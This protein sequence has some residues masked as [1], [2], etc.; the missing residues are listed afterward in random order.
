MPPF[1]APLGPGDSAPGPL[2]D[3]NV[4]DFGTVLNGG[5]DNGLGGD[6]LST[7]SALIRGDQNAGL[8][9]FDAVPK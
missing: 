2:E 7:P 4:L 8:A 9:I 6:G 3:E 5:I 1:V